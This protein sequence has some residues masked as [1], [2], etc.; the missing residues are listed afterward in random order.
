M[1]EMARTI[2]RRVTNP[3]IRKV[4]RCGCIGLLSLY[5]GD[6]RAGKE[7]GITFDTVGSYRF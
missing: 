7:M 1:E 3:H 2:V 6:S 4:T 5:E